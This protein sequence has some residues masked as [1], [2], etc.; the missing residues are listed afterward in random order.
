VASLLGDMFRVCGF[1]PRWRPAHSRADRGF[2]NGGIRARQD[3][4]ARVAGRIV[5]AA[6]THRRRRESDRRHHT[7]AGGRSVP[8]AK[9]SERRRPSLRRT[10]LQGKAGRAGSDGCG[11]WSL[12]LRFQRQPPRRPGA[13]ARYDSV[14]G[15]HKRASGVQAPDNRASGN[16]ASRDGASGS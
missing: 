11:F 7:G 15:H 12:G 2:R 16:E 5:T 10:S 3:V 6:S 1:L 14:A 4:A 9:K 8:E 13:P